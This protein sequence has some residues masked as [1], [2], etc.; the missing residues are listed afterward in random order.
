MTTTTGATG[1]NPWAPQEKPK[2]TG[3]NNEMGKDAFLKL[4]VAQLKY[5]DPMNPADGTE[6]ISQTAQFTVV[7]RLENLVKQNEAMMQSQNAVA[8]TTLIGKHIKWTA[9]ESD[10]ADA[11]TDGV[12]TGVKLTSDG[13]ILMV[14]DWEVPMARITAV[15]PATPPPTPPGGGGTTNTTTP[16]G[17]AGG[18]GTNASTDET[19]G[20][21]A[22][23]S[24]TTT[25]EP[26]Q[27]A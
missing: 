25:T 18:T 14:G 8:G 16:A 11:P 21:D 20:T 10:E 5:Q 27:E 4:L 22:V 24:D 6:F 26:T 2:P 3:P 23:D 9:L 7:E 17:G 1:T 19:D 15:V 13:P 12:V